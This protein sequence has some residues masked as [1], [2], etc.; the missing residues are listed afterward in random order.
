MTGYKKHDILPKYMT[1]QKNEIVF[2]KNIKR[3]ISSFR[4]F[5]ESMGKMGRFQHFWKRSGVHMHT[6]HLWCM[7]CVSIN[8]EPISS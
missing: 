8:T 7:L 6:H 4:Y 2:S 3:M 5:M 1:F